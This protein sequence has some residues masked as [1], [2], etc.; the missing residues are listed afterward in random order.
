MLL[1][2]NTKFF[3][4][5]IYLYRGINEPWGKSILIS[6]QSIFHTT[7][8]VSFLKYKF[9]VIPPFKISR[10]F[11]TIFR[12][13]SIIYRAFAN[14]PI[15]C[16]SALNPTLCLPPWAPTTPTYCCYSKHAAASMPQICLELPSQDITELPASLLPG[17]CSNALFIPLE[18]PLR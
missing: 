16:F 12:I 9:D 2:N 13:K 10:A 3:N 7:I 8:R 15:T 4:A 17:L 11:P 18:M 6:V 5:F 1:Y 14:P